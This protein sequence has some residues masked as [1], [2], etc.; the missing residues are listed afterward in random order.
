MLGQSSSSRNFFMRRVR[1]GAGQA[2][3]ATMRE[4]VVTETT[5][6]AAG[7]VPRVPTS[8]RQEPHGIKS[9]R[10]SARGGWDVGAER[11]VRVPCVVVVIVVGVVLLLLLRLVAVV[12]SG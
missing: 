9:A 8:G 7:S 10:P 12:L 3:P 1:C 2:V 4:T 5:S 11:C 6:G